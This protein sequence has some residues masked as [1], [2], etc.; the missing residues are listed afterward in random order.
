MADQEFSKPVNYDAHS[1][2]IAGRTARLF[3]TSPVTPMILIVSL[4]VGLVGL[5]SRHARRIPRYRFP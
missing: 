1:L 2:G 5:F 3:I 4:L